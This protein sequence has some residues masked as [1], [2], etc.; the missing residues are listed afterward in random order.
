MMQKILQFARKSS[1]F[2]DSL[3]V[4]S[5]GIHRYLPSE[6]YDKNS[7]GP[8]ISTL[9]LWISGCGGLTSMSSF[10]LGPLIFGL[11]YKDTLIC[12]ILGTL[13][14]CLVAAYCS[15]MGPRSGLRQMCSARYLFGPW[16]VRVVSLITIIGFLGWSVT[17]SVLGGEI[18]K[19]L[20]GGRLSLSVGIVIVS[21][22][23]L[24]VALF[25]IEYV[26]KFEGVIGIFV[27]L[28]VFLLYV[29]S[30]KQYVKYENLQTLGDSGLTKVG[31]RIS[32]FTLAYSVTATWGGC[33]ADYYIIFPEDVPQVN[34]FLLTFFG[35]FLPTVFGAVVGMLIGNAAVGNE[36]WN[37]TYAE[38][39]LGG[40]LNLVF[41]RWGNFGKFLIVVFWLS[42]ITNN[43]INN[44]SSALSVQL[45]DDL[46]YRYLSRWFIVIIIFVI[47]LLC[48]L[49][50]RDHF[51]EIL[52]NF[53]PM[54]GYWISIYF[55]LLIEENVIFRSTSLVSLFRKE[56]VGPLSEN[57]ASNKCH[58]FPPFSS[59]NSKPYYN[60]EAW[61]DK[62][63]LTNGIAAT[64]GF[65]CGV[66]GA[67]VGMNQ[68]YFKGPISRYVGE[69]AAD[70]GTFLA[71]A[72][73]GVSYPLA[74]WLELRYFKK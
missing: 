69:D 4:E 47:T 27:L 11:G 39:S 40:L 24:V 67:I 21:V 60:F 53:L 12:G 55:T 59:V 36:L 68:V 57:E 42:L 43:I 46:A 74:R 15:T 13:L 73:T 62:Y 38:K 16:M 1:Q 5:K 33:A 7:W 37:E 70:L 34:L 8:Y 58:K 23:S 2:V 20:S 41:D 28:V 52:S 56:I 30:G 29:I 63:V 65:C 72:F 26:L 64:F 44:Y 49:V 25:G 14:G 71:M 6:R 18:L 35:I 50:G 54:L 61:N 31:N 66:A 17:N 19:W 3:G 9:G 22:M 32:F 10:F 45:L 48:S 51:S